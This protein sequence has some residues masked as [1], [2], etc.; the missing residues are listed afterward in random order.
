MSKGYFA[1]VNCMRELLK[2][3]ITDKPIIC[4]LEIEPRHGALSSSEIREALNEADNK[5][6]QQWAGDNLLAEV[7]EW[8]KVADTTKVEG[9]GKSGTTYREAAAGATSLHTTTSG[10]TE[11]AGGSRSIEYWEQS[12]GSKSFLRKTLACG[13]GASQA[14]GS[15]RLLGVEI[16]RKL[17]SG[18]PI[19]N[20]LYG[21]LLGDEWLSKSYAPLEWNRLG[22]FQM[23]TL[24]LIAEQLLST[25]SD[26]GSDGTYFLNDPTRKQV[27]LLT[28][29]V[30]GRVFHVYCSSHNPGARDLMEE[31][32]SSGLLQSKASKASS[33]K[34]QP[35]GTRLGGSTKEERSTEVELKLTSKREQLTQCVHMLIYLTHKT[36][37]GE[38]SKQLEQEVGLA[39]K[40]GVHLL[41]AHE[42]VGLHG[43]VDRHACDFG[44][45][46]SCTEGVTP[47]DLVM[48]RTCLAHM[49]SH[50]FVRGPLLPSIVRG[51]H[52]SARLV[53]RI[54][55][56]V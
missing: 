24:R 15:S 9:Q 20:E 1:S 32:L 42:V 35:H 25:R 28:P 55:N 34:A 13:G 10:S 39:M 3:V 54:R 41:L 11:T 14:S 26:H 38:G 8:L 47:P 31:V 23:T 6:G 5:Y 37:T 48:V 46:F 4:M 43:Q 50:L 27:L 36:W 49:S 2:A 40:H 45:F 51:V 21:I 30:T 12:K 53:I 7:I 17:V 52:A 33:G 16:G 56:S 19:A 22:V 29:A 44:T 18:L